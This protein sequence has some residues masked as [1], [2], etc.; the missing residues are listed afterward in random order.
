MKKC[1]LYLPVML[2]SMLLP[3]ACTGGSSKGETQAETATGLLQQ[4]TAAEAPDTLVGVIGDDTS[5]NLLQFITE[6]GDTLELELNDQ[7]ER[8]ATII[9]GNT[10]RVAVVY[11]SDSAMTVVGTY[12][13]AMP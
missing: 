2:A 3:C 5:M 6:Q 4:D 1:K 11:D 8:K 13:L 10:I 9:P 7:V 12:D